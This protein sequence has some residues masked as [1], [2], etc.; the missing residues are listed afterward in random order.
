M[1]TLLVHPDTGNERDTMTIDERRLTW[2]E[3]NA[4]LIYAAD[5]KGTS[6]FDMKVAKAL[7]S[8]ARTRVPKVRRVQVRFAD[9][10]A[11][12]HNADALAFLKI[13]AGH[14]GGVV[15]SGATFTTRE[16]IGM[17]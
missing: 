16:D 8:L 5:E 7:R 3:A 11:A 9:E 12:A 14:P 1:P 4:L 13:E 17:G 15:A 6:T 10:A 2:D